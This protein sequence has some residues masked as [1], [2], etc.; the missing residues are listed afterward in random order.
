MG[1]FPFMA[2][3]RARANANTDG[4]VKFIADKVRPQMRFTSRYTSR[5]TSCRTRYTS[6]YT[7]GAAA[8]AFHEMRFTSSVPCASRTPLA[9]PLHQSA[10]LPLLPARRESRCRIIVTS[11]YISIVTPTGD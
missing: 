5:Y 6:R 7:R 11:G 9:E 2:N 1:K 4:L 3:S 10:S 8:D